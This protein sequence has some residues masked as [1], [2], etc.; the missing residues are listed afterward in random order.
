MLE[1]LRATG[2]EVTP[3]APL[4]RRVYWRCGGPAEYLVQVT[5]LAQLQALLALPVPITVLGRGSNSL[6]H[7]DGIPG[8]VLILRGELADLQ[9]EGTTATAG[10]GMWL[11]VLLSRLDRAGLAGA[12][13]L[14]GIP[15]TVGGAVTMNAGTRMGEI[16][17]VVQTV[18]VVLPGGQVQELTPADLQFAY[19]HAE[20]PQGAVIA[21]AVL[22]LTDQDVSRKRAERQAFLA[23]RKASQPLNK[24]SCGSTF[25]NPP[26]DAAGRL[27]D[28]CGLKGTRVGG[29]V[30]SELHANFV[31][32][33]GGATAA[34]VAALIRLARERV[35]AQ[36]G[37]WMTPEVR[38]LGPWPDDALGSVNPQATR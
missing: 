37:V 30:I 24:P 20:L 34:D 10:A 38:L 8:A 27:I 11:N 35:Y 12:E 15:G 26:G 3:N 31:L 29:A 7:D 25:T 18:R 33:D 1:Q 13:S 16:C 23:R 5:T 21:Q 4:A 28:A 22:A 2:A 9:L 17:D 36:T 32:N 6:V 19:R 14:V